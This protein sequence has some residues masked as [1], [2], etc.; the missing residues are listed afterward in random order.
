LHVLRKFHN[1]SATAYTDSEGW[2]RLYKFHDIPVHLDNIDDN[3][4]INKFYIVYIGTL[5]YTTCS[6][7]LTIVGELGRLADFDVE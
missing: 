4:Q 6:W 2:L 5:N 1:G 3:Y 7:G